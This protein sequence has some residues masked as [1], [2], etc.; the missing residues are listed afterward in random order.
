[1]TIAPTRWTPT[2]WIVVEQAG[3]VGEQDVHTAKNVHAA[4]A[5]IH[6]NYTDEEVD[7]LRIDICWENA[8]GERS[9]EH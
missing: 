6:A 4:Y 5:W 9:Y 2:R 8:D 7:D 3:Y 1:M